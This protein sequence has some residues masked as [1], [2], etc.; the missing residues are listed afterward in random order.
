MPKQ[1]AGSSSTKPRPKQTPYQRLQSKT[2]LDEYK[3]KEEER[4]K[5]ERLFLLAQKVEK[6]EDGRAEEPGS[7]PDWNGFCYGAHVWGTMM[8][9]VAYAHKRNYEHD[10]GQTWNEETFKRN[11]N[12]GGERKKAYV[13]GYKAWYDSAHAEG[14]T[15]LGMMFTFT[16][17]KTTGRSSKSDPYFGLRGEALKAQAE[18]AYANA[19]AVGRRKQAAKAFHA[20]AA[21]AAASSSSSGAGSSTDPLPEV[22][23]RH[24]PP[25]NPGPVLAVSGE[26]RSPA[27]AAAADAA[28][29]QVQLTVPSTPLAPVGRYDAMQGFL[30]KPEDWHTFDAGV[31]LQEQ[32]EDAVRN[33]VMFE[34]DAALEVEGLPKGTARFKLLD[35]TCATMRP[36]D[37]WEFGNFIDDHGLTKLLR[38]DESFNN[39]RDEDKWPDGFA[40]LRLKYVSHGGYNSVW[41]TEAYDPTDPYSVNYRELPYPEEVVDALN[42]GLAVLRAPL[43]RPEN[44]GGWRP[45]SAVIAEMT[46]MATAALNGY[47]PLIIAMGW[48]KRVVFGEPELRLYTFLQRGTMD[49][50][51][52][53]SKITRAPDWARDSLHEYFDRLLRAVWGYSSDRCVFVDAKLKNFVDFFPGPPNASVALEANVMG[54][55]R[56]IDLAE[57]GFRRMWRPP[58]DPQGNT[59]TRAQGW[60][61]YWL[62]N[63]LVISC[64]VRLHLPYDYYL[65]LWWNKIEAAVI[66]LR[67]ELAQGRAYADD[68]EYRL[69]ADF[70]RACKW[71][72]PLYT[73]TWDPTTNTYP[74]SVLPDPRVGNDPEAVAEECRKF[75]TYYFHD[76]W[77]LDGFKNYAAV[78][79]SERTAT[80]VVNRG[81]VPAD[82]VAAAV[83]HHRDMAIRH[84]QFFVPKAVPMH[85]H[86]KE[87][88][89]PNNES[90]STLVHVM[91]QYCAMSE[92]ELRKRYVLGQPPS[93]IVRPWPRMTYSREHK[94]ISLQNARNR[95]YWERT[96]G[97]S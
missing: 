32:V 97:F 90:A 41:T 76:F 7:K 44:R 54:T 79:L 58:V 4:I 45:Q 72:G 95:M 9:R 69:A 66:R 88:L 12:Q 17:N 86:F 8:T 18:K 40:K 53:V 30:A 42:K 65:E 83:A 73:G 24:K 49:V 28:A 89:R 46:N 93:R 1:N 39:P 77:H 6:I 92:D 60:R 52:R 35:T 51:R 84:D 48:R 80:A 75:A 78:V 64:F 57:D 13:A 67:T 22:A 38:S 2:A 14:T 50:D 71:A 5:E 68:A 81:R 47:G 94:N 25:S 82:R 27:E 16:S 37:G 63:I 62:H 74:P 23:S 59:H 87:H 85:R 31:S 56:V 36:E 26:A 34:V 19:Q 10:E 21:P 20:A 29:E 70:V 11:F 55:V 33:N 91:Y 43:T 3:R 61:L 96:L 15:T